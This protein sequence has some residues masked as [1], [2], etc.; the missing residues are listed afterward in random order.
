MP[1]I[2]V[3]FDDQFLESSHESDRIVSVVVFEIN[4]EH[5]G[6]IETPQSN[7]KET[8][9]TAANVE[10]KLCLSDQLGSFIVTADAFKRAH[11]PII[12]KA[13]NL[14]DPQTIIYPVQN[15]GLYCTATYGYS[16][17]PYSGSM[18]VQDQNG[19][20]P[21]FER[22]CL[23]LYQALAILLTIYCAAY[24]FLWHTVR[25]PVR[26]SSPALLLTAL[27]NV[28]MHCLY[29]VLADAGH[30]IKPLLW[31]IA[32]ITSAQTFLFGISLVVPLVALPRKPYPA[33][34]SSVPPTAWPIVTILAA[35]MLFI[36]IAEQPRTV[37][38]RP[39]F[40][41]PLFAALAAAGLV[42]VF[43]QGHRQ[44]Y[45]LNDSM[46]LPPKLAF[47]VYYWILACIALLALA[48]GA[49]SIM[50]IV[51]GS[52]GPLFAVKYWTTR[53]IR[54][55]E[56]LNLLLLLA[57]MTDISFCTY[58][59]FRSARLDMEVVPTAESHEMTQG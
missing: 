22:P 16:G 12:T 36:Q 10:A 13:I 25:S 46:F 18:L 48:C 43:F 4:D 14:S 3:Q 44:A 8:I 50:V 55:D 40:V 1:S 59:A 20:L 5:L 30:H 32:A 49:T 37:E 27:L 57:T 45:L 35:S 7:T 41:M 28:Y 19:L 51:D 29:Y 15:H 38:T 23:R 33:T 2:I 6:G 11:N 52:S 24:A 17:H 34:F 9:C 58:L 54:F 31:V 42:W 21:A 53:W 47:T 26:H 39:S 56:P